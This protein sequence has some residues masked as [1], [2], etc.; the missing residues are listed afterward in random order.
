MK[1][2]FVKLGSMLLCVVMLASVG[3]SD[4]K[5]DING[6]NTKVENV[7]GEVTN[8]KDA[9]SQLQT[10]LNADFATKQELS[11][12]QT[13]IEGK[14]GT[15]V[16]NLKAQI[17][18][19]TA[20][21][22]EKVAQSDF[23]AVAGD[24]ETLKEG[25]AQTVEALTNLQNA[26]ESTKADL[27]GAVGVNA[28]AIADLTARLT[29]AETAAKAMASDIEALKQASM[30][31][32]EAIQN[33]AVQCA[34]LEANIEAANAYTDKMAEEIY[35]E[36]AN[37]IAM[38]SSVANLV[39][40]LQVE[41]ET[42]YN[43]IEGVRSMV[44]ALNNLI[45]DLENED[46]EIYKQLNLAIEMI[47]SVNTKLDDLAAEDALIYNEVEAVR[48]MISS[49]LALH[50]D[51]VSEVDDLETRLAAIEAGNDAEI[52]ALQE[53]HALLEANLQATL[54]KMQANDEAFMEAY[55][56][57]EARLQKTL[58]DMQNDIV[59]LQDAHADLEARLQ[60]TLTDMQNDIEAIK[61]AYADLEARLQKT[62]SEMQAADE[63]FKEAYMDLNANLEKT[64]SEMLA[65]DESFREAYMD[66]NAN[67]EKALSR[68][69]K[70]IEELEEAHSEDVAG[71]QNSVTALQ[72]E[73]NNLSDELSAK[74]EAAR[75]EL[76]SIVLAPEKIVDGVAVVEF[77]SLLYIP[78]DVDSDEW[79]KADVNNI[80]T[81]TVVIDLPAY[82]YYHFN[83]SSF[84]YEG[85]EFTTTERRVKSVSH[86]DLPIATVG[87]LTA[88][89]KGTVK[90]ELNRANRE[91]SFNNFF[92]L[93]A[94]LENGSVV[95]SDY[96]KVVDAP[97]AFD[98][99]IYFGRY[100]ALPKSFDNVNQPWDSFAYDSE[101]DLSEWVNTVT[102][103]GK[104]YT[105]DEL[106]AYGFKYRYSVP[107]KHI[108]NEVNQQESIKVNPTTGVVTAQHGKEAIGRR[109]IV[110]IELIDADYN[111]VRRAY[112]ALE[113]TIDR[114]E[115]WTYNHENT[116][117]T[118][119]RGGETKVVI[120][121]EEVR[122]KIYRALDIAQEEFNKIYTVSKSYVEN[123]PTVD[124]TPEY[125]ANEQNTSAWEF[126]W[127]VVYDQ[128]ELEAGAND[129]V[130]IVELTNE[131][132]SSTYP[133]KVIVKIPVTITKNFTTI[134]RA[135][136]SMDATRVE[137]KVDN[138]LP[139]VYEL[140]A[141]ENTIETIKNAT[142]AVA[143]GDVLKAI[144]ILGGVPGF[145]TLET[146]FTGVAEAP[147]ATN[148]LEQA[149]LYVTLGSE[150]ISEL[151]AAWEAA[152]EKI[153]AGLANG[154]WGKIIVAVDQLK[155]YTSTPLIGSYVQQLVDV[156]D[157]LVA[158]GVNA[159]KWV[160]EISSLDNIIPQ[161]EN[162]DVAL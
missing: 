127:N 130:G 105:K 61:E 37:V 40:D 65:A 120:T 88:G 79:T 18:A 157:A 160:P 147:A 97:A 142:A 119:S 2:H 76:K 109:P 152:N 46:T 9:L 78:M 4:I 41:D 47:S 140:Y 22:A 96:A 111:I 3:C 63:A 100:L 34:T 60:K 86:S 101:Y 19:L 90:V 150:A 67:L 102:P 141:K 95:T 69:Q 87:A 162:V 70:D 15:E 85:V 136:A 5:E 82:A 72:T 94:N 153:E 33:L 8:L 121:P 54:S 44:S 77:P 154:T 12:L 103:S 55:A 107:E 143:D 13:T 159:A 39:A 81:N 26:L 24:V 92:A 43:E 83:P 117:L 156:L 146:T 48:G 52:K 32:V 31:N 66:L 10:K 138:I 56:D 68:M 123:H 113:I 30:L 115:A 128:F 84:D 125:K 75:K 74:I 161:F 50:N 89:P 155:N 64:L 93:Q 16:N 135:T 29:A 145:S 118:C 106:E 129:F 98:A 49:V 99:A 7:A 131:I 35:S 114:P 58:T 139:W 148:P 6:V 126:N 110:K 71:I 80:D 108:V 104:V 21:V 122:T 144:A 25:Y 1:K 73:L 133:S 28:E 149:A 62:L 27:E 23:D 158:V 17:E 59:A 53:A 91:T 36:I 57:L 137:F 124:S 151:K 42:I 134:T 14:I 20:A 116:E 45:T 132:P 112:I 11:A 51:L 38:V